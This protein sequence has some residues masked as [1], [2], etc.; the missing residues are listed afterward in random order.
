MPNDVES[1]HTQG[2]RKAFIVGQTAVGQ[3]TR[4][5]CLAVELWLISLK[6]A[7]QNRLDPWTNLPSVADY[8]KWLSQ[9]SKVTPIPIL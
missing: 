2:Y 1:D 6:I 8:N 3:M 5:P 7:L 4:N 9:E